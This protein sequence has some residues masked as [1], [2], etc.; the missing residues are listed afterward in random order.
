M[1]ASRY[2]SFVGG[3]N[4]EDNDHG[5]INQIV[6]LTATSQWTPKAVTSY[7]RM[8]ADSVAV[9]AATARRVAFKLARHFIADD[10]PPDAVAK[11]ARVFPET[12][13]DLRQVSLALIDLP[14][15]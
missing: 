9:H 4:P 12:E 14:E 1:R 10:P 15:V 5:I 7:A 13:G 8:F 11:L 2:R 6:A 3:V